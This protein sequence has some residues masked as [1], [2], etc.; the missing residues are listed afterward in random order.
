MRKKT[1]AAS[2]ESFYTSK[3]HTFGESRRER[4][5]TSV[6]PGGAREAGRRE[7]HAWK[8]GLLER[9][10]ALNAH[11]TEFVTRERIRP[12]PRRQLPIQ[13][14]WPSWTFEHVTFTSLIAPL[15][16]EEFLDLDESRSSRSS[17]PDVRRK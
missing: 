9:V 6:P 10:E 11:R 8:R 5:D 15:A 4:Q 3:A 7:T 2:S 13:P 16:L 14:R 1:A 17:S 12:R